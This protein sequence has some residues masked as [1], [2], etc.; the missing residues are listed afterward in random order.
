MR[1]TALLFSTL[2]LLTSA[3]P[4]AAGAGPGAAGVSAAMATHS[5]RLMNGGELPLGSLRGHVV[6]LNFWASWCGPCR[7]ELPQLAVLDRELSKQGGR[8]IAV[9]IDEDVRNAAAFASRHAAGMTVYH[10]GP[11]GLIR[12]L[13]LPALPWTVV[14]DRDG[15][16]AWSGGGASAATLQHIADTARRLSAAPAM[17]TESTEGVS[18]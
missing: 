2:C 9:S 11:Q 15:A 18:R 1:T 5:V 17:L 12:T 14:L 8:V 13:D 10:D 6:V 16:V 4:V 3:A 7:K